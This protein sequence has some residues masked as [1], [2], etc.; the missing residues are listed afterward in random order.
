MPGITASD[1]L[2]DRKCGICRISKVHFGAGAE[3]A[4]GA[5]WRY[6][7]RRLCCGSMARPPR[8]LALG[9]LLGMKEL[10]SHRGL[11][12]GDRSLSPE[13]SE[14]L[15]AGRAAKPRAFACQKLLRRYNGAWSCSIDGCSRGR[16]HIKPSRDQTTL[17]PMYRSKKPMHWVQ[18]PRGNVVMSGSRSS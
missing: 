13:E 11:G 8:S 14:A 5:V 18:H 16:L 12:V 4:R 2:G 1:L 10:A 9:G 17:A 3:R 6:R 7:R 15:L